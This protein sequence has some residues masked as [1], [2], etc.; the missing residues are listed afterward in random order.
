MTLEQLLAAGDVDAAQALAIE[1][2][3]ADPA[4]VEPRVALARIALVQEDVESAQALIE[5]LPPGEGG[6]ARSLVDATLL[7]AKDK[8][9]DAIE[10]YRALTR[11]APERFEGFLGLGEAAL[12]K[13][14]VELAVRALKKA[15]LTDDENWWLHY[16]VGIALAGAGELEEAVSQLT[17]ALELNPAD[18]RPVASLA[19]GLME[20]GDLEGAEEL[21]RDYFERE[22]EPPQL[23]AILVQVLVRTGELDEARHLAVLLADANPEQP[24]FQTEAARL[25]LTDGEVADATARCE[26]VIAEGNATALTHVVRAQAAELADPADT[27]AALRHYAAALELE[28]DDAGIHTNLGLLLVQLD[29]LD[30]AAEHLTR[31][32]ELDGDSAP[33]LYN[34][35]LLFAKQG[36]TAQARATLS[37]A[38]EGAD[39]L[40][41]AEVQRLMAALPA[42]G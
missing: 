24:L 33:A 37:R 40:L 4:S 5:P 21:L 9:G 31:A 42:Q 18:E 23:V 1:Q 36:D 3:E 14:D 41:Q 19:A 13:G 16:R 22:G 34:L 39:P 8:L 11:E 6:Y 35:G 15:A 10:A 7:V 38:L 12:E 17:R 32:L 29:R 25:L 30:D 2:L 28:P 26:R 20:A 27:D